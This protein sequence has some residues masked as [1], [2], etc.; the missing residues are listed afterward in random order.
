MVSPKYQRTIIM[1]LIL[2]LLNILIITNQIIMAEIAKNGVVKGITGALYTRT[3]LGKQIIQTR[4]NRRN[5]RG[6]LTSNNRE[7]LI[8][9]KFSSLVRVGINYFLNFKQDS[10]M[11]NR[12]NSAIR[13]CFQKNLAIENGMRNPFNTSMK[14]LEG[15]EFNENKNFKDVVLFPILIEQDNDTTIQITIP[16]FYPLEQVI[17]APKCKKAVLRL[18]STSVINIENTITEG[19]P[20]IELEFFAENKMISLLPT[21]INNISTPAYK[22]VV[23][24]ICFYYQNS[25]S[26]EW[27]LYNTKKYNPAMILGSFSNQA[28]LKQ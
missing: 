13:K 7:F 14:D 18:Y 17:F 3:Y 19:S 9:S 27:F 23:G 16:D 1:A 21:T 12:L 20:I 5:K 24:E 26:E 22:I 28:T 8:T 11:H 15:F 10:K 2:W 25:G 4:P 6:K